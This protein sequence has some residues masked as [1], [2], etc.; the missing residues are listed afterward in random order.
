MN[1]EDIGKP[2]DPKTSVESIAQIYLLFVTLGGD[3]GKVAV[4]ADV[5]PALVQELA[6]KEDWNKRLET[7]ARLTNANRSRAQVERLI[8]RAATFV[9]CMRARRLIDGMLTEIEKEVERGVM[10]RDMFSYTDQNGNKRCDLKPLSELAT[11]TQKLAQTAFQAMSDGAT[12][13]RERWT[14]EKDVRD[15]C[16]DLGAKVMEGLKR[17]APGTD[18]EGDAVKV[19]EASVSGSENVEDSEV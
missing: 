11:A 9:Q 1:K 6:E 14:R 13:R 19:L 12:D 15:D 16:L 5:S 8:N 4:A 2:S 17:L 7:T 10:L 3:I 18:S